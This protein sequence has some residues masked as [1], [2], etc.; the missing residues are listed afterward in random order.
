MALAQAQVSVSTTATLLSGTETD[1]ARGQTVVVQNPS[2]SVD[3][4][5]GTASV[6]SSVYGYVLKASSS[7]AGNQLNAVAITLQ[8]GETLYGIVASGTQ[9]VNVLRTGV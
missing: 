8:A 3:V 9:T 2:T 5:L 4:F 6:T 7:T 1:D